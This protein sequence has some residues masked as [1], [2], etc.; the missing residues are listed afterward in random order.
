M[1]T[2][3]NDIPGK[4][5]VDTVLAN[6]VVPE[7]VEEI[8][9]ETQEES[10]DG[11]N[12]QN[13]MEETKSYEEIVNGSDTSPFGKTDSDADYNGDIDDSNADSHAENSAKLQ[14]LE[15]FKRR[16]SSGYW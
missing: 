9:S 6:K 16:F 3:T 5:K 1:K 14:Q 4:D 15:T 2:E 10:K 13:D 12:N 8:G 11:K 7:K